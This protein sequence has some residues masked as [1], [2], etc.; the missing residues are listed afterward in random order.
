M[1]GKPVIGATGAILMS[2]WGSMSSA[3]DFGLIMFDE[4]G[5]YWCEQ[6]L[7]EIGPIYP[8]TLAGQAA[9][10]SVIGISEKLPTGIELTSTP[11]YTPTFILT[12]NG[13]EVGKIEGYPGEDFFWWFL[14]EML[15]E[16]PEY[17]ELVEAS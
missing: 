17:V 15:R 8:K 10:L 6:W 1:F 13:K 14:E 2:L 12:Q 4:P 5:C 3:D 11:V 16:F 7:E 9:P